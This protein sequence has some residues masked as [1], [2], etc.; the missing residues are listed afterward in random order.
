LFLHQ[1]GTGRH[2]TAPTAQR[3]P[4]GAATSSKT[5]A[6]SGAAVTGGSA[7]AG[8][9]T[10]SPTSAPATTTKRAPAPTHSRRS[11]SGFTVP[12]GFTVRKDST[13]FSVA[14]PKGWTRSV[15]GT[16]TYYRDPSGRGYLMVDQTT[17]PKPDALKDKQAQEKLIAA[18]WPH[19]HRIRL[20][21]VSYKGWDTA[22]WEYTWRPSGGTLHVLNRNIRVNSKQA[23][24]LYWS[25][26]AAEWTKR[27]SDFKTIAASFTSAS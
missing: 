20:E 2:S 23:Y 15:S 6:T 18:T 1:R 22:D 11:S 19:Y 9:A 21:D 7:S 5:P 25:I 10:T 17:H 4:T 3:T 16:R 12:A 24:A 26:P 8:S 14:V 27:W 13:G